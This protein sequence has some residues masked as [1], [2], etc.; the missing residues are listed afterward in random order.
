MGFATART[1]SAERRHRPPHRRPGRR[2][3][4]PGRHR[5]RRAAR[6]L[7][8]RGARPVPRGADQQRLRVAGDPAGHDPAVAGRP[9]Q[10]RPALRPRDRGGR[11]GAAA[12][13]GTQTDARATEPPCSTATCSSASSASTAG[14]AA[15]PGVLPMVMAAQAQ[16]LTP[17]RGPEPQA[18]EAAMVPGIEVFGVRSLRAGRRRAPRASRSPTRRRW[19]RWPAGSCW[20]GEVT[21]G[22]ATSTSRTCTGMAD[23]R[24]ALEVAAAGGH[25]LLLSGPKGAG[26]TT[27]AERLP[28]LLP[29]LGLEEALELS[30]IHSLAGALDPGR[31][32]ITRP[33]FRAPHHSATQASLLGG[34]TG[35]VRPGRAEPGAARLPVPRRVPAVQRRHHRGAAPAAGERRGHDR[36]RARRP[37]PSR[38]ARWSC[39][40][41]TRARAASTTPTLRTTAAPAPRSRRRDYREQDQ[42]P[43]HRPHRHHP[44]RRAGAARTS[45][46][47]RS[48]HRSR[49]PPCGRVSPRRAS[50]RRSGTQARPGGSTPTCRVPSCASGW[51]LTERG[52]AAARRPSCTPGALTRRGATRVHRLAWTVADL[53]GRDQ[54]R[55]AT[56]STSRFG[57]APAIR[58]SCARL[59]TAGRPMTATDRGRRPAGPGGAGPARRAGRPAGA[60]GWSPRG[61]GS[62]CVELLRDERDLDG[63]RS[64]VAQRLRGL[65]PERDLADAPRQGIR[66]VVP[67]DEEWPAQARRP[68]PVRAPR[69]ARAAHRSGCGSRARS[70]RRD[71]CV[72]RWRSSG[73]RSATTYGTDVAGEHRRRASA[74]S[75]I[76]V[77][78][79]AAFGIDARSPPRRAGRRGPTVAVLACG[80][81]RAYP[82][83]HQSLLDH[84]AEHRTGRLARCRP[85]VPRPG[86]G[87]SP[88]TGSSP[89]CPRA[90]WSSRQRYAAARSTPPT[91]PPGST[92]S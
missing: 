60:P 81:D 89:P 83:G 61:C 56:S 48:R 41:A 77:V 4:G 46:T 49:P 66:F 68:R 92:A 70:P 40:R 76:S 63:L 71:D 87:S 13:T 88:A 3:A 9:A 65:D 78:S 34:G 32:L 21:A 58:W 30:A 19:S 6:R 29:D 8:Q 27:L 12:G 25:H 33:P 18:E 86:C 39:S 35:R 17:R 22:S 23:A 62:V 54:S 14:S 50:A 42:R 31:P 26:K 7:D 36:P 53:R 28:G 10:A 38:H 69:T 67:G 79:G 44:A 64:D 47:T 59:V 90:P 51:P 15:V 55:A 52:A 82:A 57:C 20:R 84:I 37:R 74:R 2:L 91:G 11:A 73:S 16:G 5:A 85:A 80:V 75:G 24:Y 1:V 43:G 45:C 72:A